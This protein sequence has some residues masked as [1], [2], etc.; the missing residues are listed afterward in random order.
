MESSWIALTFASSIVKDIQ[1]ALSE[2]T[3]ITCKL[4]FI[5]V[6]VQ[7]NFSS[8]TGPFSKIWSQVQAANWLLCTTPLTI[9]VTKM[10]ISTSPLNI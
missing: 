9:F 6:I 2:I 8:V 7:M 3:V 1:R 10:Q 4:S 5:A